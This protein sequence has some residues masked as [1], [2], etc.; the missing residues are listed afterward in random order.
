[1]PNVNVIITAGGTSQRYGVENKLF[2]DLNGKPVIKHSVDLFTEMGYDIVITSHLSFIEE[3]QKIFENYQNIQIIQGGI[4]RQQSVYRGL[5]ALQDKNC[6]FVII[7]DAARPL[8]KKETVEKCLQKAYETKAA[9]IAVHTTDTIKTTDI[10]KKITGTP[11]RTT[12]I[13]VQTPQIF[14]YQLILSEH[15]KHQ[16][17]TLTDDASLLEAS[18]IDIYYVEGEYSNIKITNKIDIA[19]AKILLDTM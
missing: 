19:Y 11:N 9:I 2:E 3:M 7:H 10:N 5:K 15:A 14:D 4:S 18:N 6:D 8:I 13:N 16:D 17:K 12:L 1:M